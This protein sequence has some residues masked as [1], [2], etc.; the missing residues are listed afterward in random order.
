[1]VL[2]YLPTQLGDLCWANMEHMANK[3]QELM[4]ICWANAGCIVGQWD[5]CLSLSS[6]YLGFA[7]KKLSNQSKVPRENWKIQDIEQENGE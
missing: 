1:M 4:N 7:S 5:R 2:V 6:V 3:R